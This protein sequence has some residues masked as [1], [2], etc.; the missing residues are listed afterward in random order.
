MAARALLFVKSFAR[1]H[2]TGLPGERVLHLFRGC[3]R[4][5]K[6]LTLCIRQCGKTKDNSHHQHPVR[7]LSD[8]S[9]RSS[10]KCCRMNYDEQCLLDDFSNPKDGKQIPLAPHLATQS[11]PTRKATPCAVFTYFFFQ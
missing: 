6:G 11:P 1:L 3:G 10:P 8:L 5:M 7:P 2:G 9:Q 4:P